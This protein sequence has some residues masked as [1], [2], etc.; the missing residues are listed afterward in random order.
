MALVWQILKQSSKH[1]P[2]PHSS[3][4]N[5][6]FSYSTCL[7]ASCTPFC[8]LGLLLRWKYLFYKSLAV[9]LSSVGVLMVFQDEEVDS[10]I[11]LHFS[12]LCKEQRHYVSK[13]LRA[14]WTILCTTLCF[15]FSLFSMATDLSFNLPV[16]L[17]V[18]LVLFLSLKLPPWCRC[19]MY[20]MG[21]LSI[22]LIITSCLCTAV[23]SLCFNFAS[24]PTTGTSSLFSHSVPAT[25]T[26]FFFMRLTLAN[27]RN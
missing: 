25:F 21:F 4:Q 7:A 26:P 17:L 5:V 13:Y 27:C 20:D 11:S 19:E 22:H 6:F 2:M 23:C 9:S 15:S 18:Y 8:G 16:H 10:Y 3:H 12:L 14:S 24:F 1:K